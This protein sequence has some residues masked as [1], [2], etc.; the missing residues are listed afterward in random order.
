MKKLS[1]TLAALMLIS[2]C[3]KNE[4]VAPVVAETCSTGKTCATKVAPEVAVSYFTQFKDEVLGTCDDKANLRFAWLSLAE[5]VLIG[6]N[7]DGT[8]VVAELNLY[9]NNTDNT[10]TGEY[11]ENTQKLNEDGFYE[12]ISSKNKRD[13]V[14]KWSVQGSQ[15]LIAGIGTG[16]AV[17]SNFWPGIQIKVEGKDLSPVLD[18]VSIVMI[19][20]RSMISKDSKTIAQYCPEPK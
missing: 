18:T 13:L 16:D 1:F 17:T 7:A 4:S 5:R 15:I 20:T 19:K 6:K 9:L 11:Q 12:T 3:G 10:Y 2:G 14:G 8:D